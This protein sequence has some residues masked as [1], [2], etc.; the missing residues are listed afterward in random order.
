MGFFSFGKK[1]AEIRADTVSA[2]EIIDSPILLQALLGSGDPVT[3]EL[4]LEIPTVQVCISLIAG[5]IAA[6]NPDFE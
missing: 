6:L 5:T 2:M 4:A 3:K 1:K